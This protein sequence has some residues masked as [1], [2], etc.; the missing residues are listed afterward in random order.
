MEMQQVT[1]YGWSKGH[2]PSI[3][4]ENLVGRQSKKVCTENGAIM[5]L[6]DNVDI[7]LL[8]EYSL[9]FT[10]GDGSGD[11]SPVFVVKDGMLYHAC[12]WYDL[13]E[14]TLRDKLLLKAERKELSVFDVLTM[15]LV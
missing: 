9:Y 8:N 13:F 10:I 6:G 12:Y 5:K 2:K 15:L 3:L 11:G 1:N 14:S 4:H 7:S